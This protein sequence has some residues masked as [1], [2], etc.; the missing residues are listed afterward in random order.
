MAR[1]IVLD[2]SVAVAALARDDVHHRAASAALTSAG[3]DELVLAATTRAEILLGPTRVGGQALR[4]ARDFVDACATIPIS[5]GLADDAAAL[6]AAHPPLSLPDAPAL[7]V[8]RLIEAD[9][10]WTFDRR[11][12]SVDPRVRI[13]IAPTHG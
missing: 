7:S 11:W 2:A 12:P 8:A 13:P 9:L 6:K 5:A 4:G 10:M 3:D 1:L